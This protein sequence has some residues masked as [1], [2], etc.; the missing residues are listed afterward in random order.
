M[1]LDDISHRFNFHPAN[2]EEKKQMALFEIG[3]MVTENMLFSFQETIITCSKHAPGTAARYDYK[4]H[5]SL[6]LVWGVPT[7]IN[8]LSF[9]GWADFIAAKGNDEAGAGTKP[10]THIY[11]TLMYDMS[12]SVGASRNTFKVGAGYEY[13]KNKFGNDHTNIAGPGQG[14]FAKTPFVKAEY[15]F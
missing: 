6:S 10:E 4:D 5:P 11:A 2:D 14:A 15:H 8:D 9:S 1:S 3:I 7:G 13:W 12:A